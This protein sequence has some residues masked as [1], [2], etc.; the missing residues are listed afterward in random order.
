GRQF[1]ERE[2]AGRRAASRNAERLT[3]IEKAKKL[4]TDPSSDPAADKAQEKFFFRTLEDRQSHLCVDC[5]LDHE[6]PWKN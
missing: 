3:L 4:A 2:A 1:F 6:M 5:C